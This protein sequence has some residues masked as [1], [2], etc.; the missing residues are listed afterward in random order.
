MPTRGIG[1]ADRLSM[2]R[3]ASRRSRLVALTETLRVCGPHE[4][5]AIARALLTELKAADRAMDALAVAA[6]RWERLRD[7]T[8]ALWLSAAGDRLS[9]MVDT[10]ARSAAPEQRL[11]AAA[12][13]ERFPN[14]AGAARL[15]A[16]LEDDDP[17]VA[18]SAEGALRT[19]LERA[20]GDATLLA[21]LDA[22]LAQAAT[23][24]PDHRRRGV[25][26]AIPVLLDLPAPGAPRLREWLSD[27]NQPALLALRAVVRGDRSDGARARALRLLTFPTL[28]PAA[29]SR[30]G[31]RASVREHQRAFEGA[32]LLVREAR[33]D[34]FARVRLDAPG[35]APTA[36]E[37]ASMPESARAGFVRFVARCGSPKGAKAA[38][39]SRTLCDPS[40]LVRVVA[41]RELA[42][43]PSPDAEDA[44][45]TAGLL[46]DL[47]FVSSP[48]V[49]G[50]AA[51]AL[52]ND[53]RL[54][55]ATSAE[56][57]ASLVRCAAESVRT[58]VAIAQR[59]ED[60]WRN[61]AAARVAVDASRGAFVRELLRRIAKGEPDARVA[62]LR[63]AKRLSLAREA[64]L[65]I[66]AAATDRDPRVAA[67]AAAALAEVRG[68]SATQALERLVEHPDERVRANAIEAL[69][70][71]R[72]L[73]PL[74]EVK[75]GAVFPRERANAARSALVAA[76][77]HGKAA[78]ALEAMLAS[79]ERARQSGLWAIER[80][81]AVA[82]APAVAKV[83][84][85]ASDE[86]TL[87][88]AKAAARMLLAV[89][90]PQS[91]LPKRPISRA[92]AA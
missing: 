6:L 36:K 72:P 10:L 44:A 52:L 7:P 48:G 88:R 27:T 63:I 45:A 1:L 64:E 61:P 77:T 15:P 9:A 81:R 59:H 56:T 76:P 28:A 20:P 83:V 74:V 33:T 70:E 42:R 55:R 22:A 29:A 60:P 69:G 86:H 23:S 21:V 91:E 71:Q 32:H 78:E 58:G 50:A 84:R 4:A 8:R 38:L 85:E 39:L 35:A 40:D 18:E 57:R 2:L 80:S 73:H 53:R 12:L 65:E 17:Q 79:D 87:R 89:M 68:A 3:K 26:E 41:V 24:Y 47:C 54:R 66:L 46:A 43:T 90:Q 92:E 30:L 14:A 82:L 5:D 19:L 49:A 25:L 16:L 13:I 34:E 11:A 75:L 31:K 67:T 62:A 37:L 51:G